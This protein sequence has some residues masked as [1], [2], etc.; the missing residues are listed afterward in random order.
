MI[1]KSV[2]VNKD[3]KIEVLTEKEVKRLVDEFNHNLLMVFSC[4]L[5]IAI[6]PEKLL[7]ADN[8]LLKIGSIYSRKS[9]DDTIYIKLINYVRIKSNIIIDKLN[10]FLECIVVYERSKNISVSIEK[11]YISLEWLLEEFRFLEESEFPIQ[12]YEIFKEIYEK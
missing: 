6:D 1:F 9:C 4:T 11:E 10:L 7:Y 5:D 8:I 2:I 3:T 12:V